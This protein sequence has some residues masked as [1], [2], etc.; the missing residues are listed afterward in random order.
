ME[1][2]IQE[3]TGTMES[4]KQMLTLLANPKAAQDGDPRPLVNAGQGDLAG[5]AS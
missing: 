1:G 2:H 5:D 3:L 4:I